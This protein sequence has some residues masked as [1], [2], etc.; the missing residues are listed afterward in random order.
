MIRRPPRSTRTDTRFPYTTLFRS[1][2][3]PG[4]L[5]PTRVLQSERQACQPAQRRLSVRSEDLRKLSFRDVDA[6]EELP[7][8]YRLPRL[9][10]DPRQDSRRLHSGCRLQPLGGDQ[11]HHRPLS[12]NDRSE[13]RRVGKECFSTCS[14]RWSPYN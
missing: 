14:I 10:A 5:R 13:E 4:R 7:P 2:R 12:S 11:H 3:T 1:R 8:P 9:Q 6:T